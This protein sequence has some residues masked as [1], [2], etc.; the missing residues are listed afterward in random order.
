[1]SKH[2]SFR[3]LRR[4]LSL[5]LLFFASLTFAL[6]QQFSP[7]IANVG[8]NLAMRDLLVNCIYSDEVGMMW[9]GTGSGVSMFD[10]VRVKNF[11]LPGNDGPQKRVTAIIGSPMSDLWAGNGYGLYRYSMDSEAFEPV[12]QA[13]IVGGVTDLAIDVNGTLFVA[14]T[15]GLYSITGTEVRSYRLQPTLTAAPV[16]I[17]CICFDPSGVLWICSE[18]GLHALLPNGQIS[19]YTLSLPDGGFSCLLATENTVWLGTLHNGLYAFDIGTA[20]LR[21]VMQMPIPVRDLQVCQDGC[22]LIGTDGNGVL[23][24]DVVSGTVLR[25]WSQMADAANRLTSNSVYSLLLDKRGLLWVGLYQHGVDYTL[26]QDNK[27]QVFA[28]NGFDSRGMAVRALCIR[29]K[30]ILVGTRQGL[31]F[32][33]KETNRLRV[34]AEKD[35]GAQMVF[36]ITWYNG[37]YYIGTYG[38][39]LR[40]LN[41]LTLQMSAVTL[42]SSACREVFALTTDADDRLW[43]GAE[44][45]AHCCMLG[46]GTNLKVVADYTSRNSQLPAD[47]VYEIFFDQSGR[48]W[49]CTTAGMAVYDPLTDAV[50]T[51][52]LPQSFPAHQVVRQVWQDRHGILFFLPEKGSMLAVDEVWHTHVVPALSGNNDAMFIT[53][54]NHDNLLVGTGN[55]LYYVLRDTALTNGEWNI[56]SEQR[57]DF[58]DGLPG[59]IF[60]LCK[61]QKDSDGTVWL[62]NSQGLVYLNTDSLL[63]SKPEHR[64]CISDLKADGQPLEHIFKSIAERRLSLPRGV[65]TLTVMF[66]DFSYTQPSCMTYEVM[67]QG[68]DNDYIPLTGISEYSWQNLRTGRYKLHLRCPGE[69]ENEIVLSVFVP[70][71]SQMLLLLAI[72]LLSITI[73]IGVVLEIRHRSLVRKEMER[74]QQ[75]LAQQA[76]LAEAAAN[77]NA[78]EKKYKTA[79]IPVAE[80]RKL[81]K[82]V[83]E[84][85][86]EQQLYLNPELKLSDIANRLNTS[87]FV[88]S[89]L[90]S[91]HMGTSFYDY[92]NQL[93]V[94]E[95]KQRVKKG[96]SKRYTLDALATRCGYNSRTSFFRNFKKVTGMTPSEYIAGK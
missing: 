49:L 39:G 60:T 86:T 6:P 72:I 4:T 93:R 7:Y 80:L 33:D 30:Q 47:R 45:G 91:Q 2:L 65:R 15:F 10:G 43:V 75:L 24:Y 23:L 26:W 57:F 89:Y 54:D 8:S 62:G 78:E 19:H 95:F 22:L 64:L 17:R 56:L 85:M 61:P 35:L 36:A 18:T 79:N 53:D 69:P 96:E 21:Q 68:V 34:F 28:C 76:A 71:S 37:S 88:L 58:S 87:S 44:D 31:Y 5:I 29:G 14:T 92:I 66:S 90:F 55:G 83:D 48:G 51:D 50:R 12:H 40:R 13:D 67:M 46:S 41:P 73:I 3:S 84:L 9:F 42:S 20:E 82:Q 74:E 63:L 94:E 81:K 27:T 70:L 59:G 38:G 1:M 52:I 16:G 25:H 77:D 32:I 11:D